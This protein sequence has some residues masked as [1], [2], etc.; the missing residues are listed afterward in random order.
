MIH[1]LRAIWQTL[2]PFYGGDRAGLGSIFHDFDVLDFLQGV[3]R[4]EI[5]SIKILTDI[6]ADFGKIWRLHN[7]L[8]GFDIRTRC[9]E[10]GLAHDV[11]VYGVG[12]HCQG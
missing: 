8:K 12:S 6:G 1:H 5:E 10:G 2:E 4:V 11:G 9:A 3:L 7:M